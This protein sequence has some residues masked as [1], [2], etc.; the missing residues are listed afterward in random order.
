M[1]ATSSLIKTDAIGDNVLHYAARFANK[2]IIESLLAISKEG[3]NDK[4]T[5][6][7]TPYQVALHWQKGE[8][9][10]LFINKKETIAKPEDTP[11]KESPVVVEKKEEVS[12]E[13]K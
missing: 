8:V 11:K 6:G 9:A 5:L 10:N 3:V 2:K 13:K 4:N 1:L 7:E 12:T